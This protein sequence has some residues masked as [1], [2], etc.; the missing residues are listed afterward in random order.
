VLS[1][2]FPAG[3]RQRTTASALLPRDLQCVGQLRG[4]LGYCGVGVDDVAQ[5]VTGAGM[6]EPLHCR[7]EARPQLGWAATAGP[8]SQLVGR[9]RAFGVGDG[10]PCQSCLERSGVS[11]GIAAA[12]S[13]S[14]RSRSRKP[15]SGGA[16]SWV[17]IAPLHDARASVTDAHA[18]SLAPAAGVPARSVGSSLTSRSYRTVGLSGDVLR[19]SSRS[20][21]RKPC[22]RQHPHTVA[23][24][25][26][27]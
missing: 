11:V 15:G 7:V 2:A 22:G 16:C 18:C 6:V 1:G 24:G 9:A 21:R 17:R 20:L 5:V 27:L 12:A 8:G 26:L 19:R 10:S 23:H 14:A 13:A 25:R 3:R 4:G